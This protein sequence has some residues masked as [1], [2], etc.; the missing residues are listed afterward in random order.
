MMSECISILITWL[1]N[2]LPLKY[3]ITV[4]Y[5]LFMDFSKIYRNSNKVSLFY[6]INYLQTN[7]SIT[8][9]ISYSCIIFQSYFHNF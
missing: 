9:F 8:I 4:V 2:I 3:V 5:I 7:I 6:A 1:V